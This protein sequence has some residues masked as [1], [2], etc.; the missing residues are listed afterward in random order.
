MLGLFD[1]TVVAQLSSKPSTNSRLSYGW[2]RAEILAALI[3]G[4]FLLALCLSIALEA[5]TRFVEIH[6]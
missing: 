1:L 5:I 2:N 6:G 4:V 3:N